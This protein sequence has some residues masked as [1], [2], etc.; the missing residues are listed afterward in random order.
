[1]AFISPEMSAGPSPRRSRMVLAIS[2]SVLTRVENE[3]IAGSG[4]TA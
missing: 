3:M 2:A 4:V 1:M